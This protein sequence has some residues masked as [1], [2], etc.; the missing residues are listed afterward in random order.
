[1]NDPHA[2]FRSLPPEGVPCLYSADDVAQLADLA[3]QIGW[4]KKRFAPPDQARIDCAVALLH[5]V[6]ERLDREHGLGVY[7]QEGGAS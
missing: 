3:C 5:Q 4:L 2:H 6:A 7:A 1:M